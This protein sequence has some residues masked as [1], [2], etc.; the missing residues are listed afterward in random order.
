MANLVVTPEDAN[1]DTIE[2]DMTAT[3]TNSSG[4]PQVGYHSTNNAIIRPARAVQQANGSYIFSLTPTADIT[5]AGL[6]Y[7]IDLGGGLTKLIQKSSA[8]ETLAAAEV[9]PD[10]LPPVAI[11]G[12]SRFVTGVIAH[13]NS[14]GRLGSTS[15]DW[16]WPNRY[17]DQMKVPLRNEMVSSST[18]LESGIVQGGWVNI[19]QNSPPETRAYGAVAYPAMPKAV[20]IQ[21]LINDIEDFDADADVTQFLLAVKHCQR[22]MIS[23][24]LLSTF[25]LHNTS[26]T[27]QTYPTGS[28]STTTDTSRNAGASYTSSGTTGAQVRVATSANAAGLNHTLLFL[29]NRTGGSLPAAT[30]T[31]TLDGVAAYPIGYTSADTF[32]TSAINPSSVGNQ[33]ITAARFEIP[34]DGASHVILAT[35]AAGGLAYNGYGVE[36]IGRLILMLNTCRRS[37]AYTGYGTDA[38]VTAVNTQLETLIEDEFANLGVTYVDVESV[39]A[40]STSLIGDGLHF[41]DDGHAECA[42]AVRTATDS[43]VL[44]AAQRKYL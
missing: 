22:A 24:L 10:D 1:A 31:F 11:Y 30:I 33:G 35:A 25:Y 3:L 13:G 40:A 37:T 34:D 32:T 9:D 5:P 18:L 36:S 16:R 28:F 2:S 15:A 23:W 12:T 8:S 6:Y 44:T 4:V 19:L 42:A 29:T 14:R 38:K 41:N 43:I 21:D 20:T 17:A 27:G 39:I 26:S 7:T